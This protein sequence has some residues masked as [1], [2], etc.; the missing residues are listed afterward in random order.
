MFRQ[1]EL[2]RDQC[3]LWRSCRDPGLRDLHQSSADVFL[4][5][6]PFDLGEPPHGFQYSIRCERERWG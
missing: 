5:K 4:Q 1:L 2:E 6:K 3:R